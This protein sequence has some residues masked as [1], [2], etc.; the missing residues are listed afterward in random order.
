MSPSDFFNKMQDYGRNP[1]N[2]YM[3]D[4]YLNIIKEKQRIGE[5][6]TQDEQDFLAKSEGRVISQDS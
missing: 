4:V 1:D 6:L 3:D 5:T 2:S